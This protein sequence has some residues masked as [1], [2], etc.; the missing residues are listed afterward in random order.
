M[1][2]SLQMMVK[3]VKITLFGNWEVATKIRFVGM[4]LSDLEG[5]REPNRGYAYTSVYTRFTKV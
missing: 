5:R 3:I 2:V 1:R 4:A